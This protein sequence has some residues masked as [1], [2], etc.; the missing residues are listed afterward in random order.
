MLTLRES[1]HHF[2]A[3]GVKAAQR[4]RFVGLLKAIRQSIDLNGSSSDH[5][6]RS[7]DIAMR[8]ISLSPLA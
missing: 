1:A 2:I 6:P 8:A 4:M 7:N 5:S 3:A